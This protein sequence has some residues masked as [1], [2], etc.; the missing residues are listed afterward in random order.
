MR[1]YAID[2]RNDSSAID[3]SKNDSSAMKCTRI[4]D[5]STIYERRENFSAMERAIEESRDDSSAIEHTIE[6]KGRLESIELNGELNPEWRLLRYQRS[7]VQRSAFRIL[8]RILF[9]IIAESE[10]RVSNTNTQ[11]V[12]R[13]SRGQGSFNDTI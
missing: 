2:R 13:S 12:Q 3:R 8:L 11:K 1:E 5:F 7:F 9:S 4:I 6:R 10:Q